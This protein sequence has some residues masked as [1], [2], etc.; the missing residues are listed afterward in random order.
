MERVWKEAVVTELRL[1]SKAFQIV[2]TSAI[3][4]ARTSG[5]H[6]GSVNL[7]FLVT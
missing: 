1:E 6:E 3:Y 4:L 5:R 7:K 2:I